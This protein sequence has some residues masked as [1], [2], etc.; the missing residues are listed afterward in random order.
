MALP[1]QQHHP[2]DRFTPRR[3]ST[4]TVNPEEN[5][6][7]NYCSSKTASS[8][9]AYKMRRLLMGKMNIKNPDKLFH[10]ASWSKRI[11]RD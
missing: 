4:S 10:S 8:P 3:G 5:G 7:L 1:A 11:C 9:L 6:Q 2:L